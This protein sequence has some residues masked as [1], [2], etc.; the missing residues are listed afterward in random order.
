[1]QLPCPD[2]LPP[3]IT[4]SD[5]PDV[6]AWVWLSLIVTIV[7]FEW[8]AVRTGNPTLSRWLRKWSGHLPWLKW[9]VGASLLVAWLHWFWL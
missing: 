1:M 7:V 4:P 8:W 3:A 6:A 9:L 5:P 2:D